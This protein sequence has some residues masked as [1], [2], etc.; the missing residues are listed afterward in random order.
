MNTGLNVSFN[1]VNAIIDL[2]VKK[3][4]LKALLILVLVNF[5][6]FDLIKFLTFLVFDQFLTFPPSLLTSTLLTLSLLAILLPKLS[7]EIRVG[8][9]VSNINVSSITV[10][11]KFLINCQ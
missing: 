7:V 4:I 10:L 2:K 1:K 3:P 9:I 6:D 8:K 5:D 11:L